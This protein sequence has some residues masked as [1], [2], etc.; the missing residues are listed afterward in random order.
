MKN[1]TNKYL[2]IAMV[3]MATLL[4]VPVISTYAHTGF[5]DTESYNYGNYTRGGFCYRG[6][7]YSEE[8]YESDFDKEELL[9]KEL[10]ERLSRYRNRLDYLV[11][12]GEITEDEKQELLD[13]EEE[14]LEARLERDLRENEEFRYGDPR[15]HHRGPYHGHHYRSNF[16]GHH[17]R[18]F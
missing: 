1:K 14:Y 9:E 18:R 7:D 15:G 16:G 13:I 5:R 11:E 17:H 6:Y 12:R 3:A 4:A 10:E 2:L 8:Y